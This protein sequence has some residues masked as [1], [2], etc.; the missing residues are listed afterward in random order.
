MKLRTLNAREQRV[1]TAI[2]LVSGTALYI[3]FALIV[4]PLWTKAM[5]LGRRVRAS[6]EELRALQAATANEAVIRDQYQSLQSSVGS[7][8][9][10]LPPEKDLPAVIEALSNIAR[11]TNVKIQTIFPQRNAADAQFAPAGTQNKAAAIPEPV[12]YRQIPIQVDAQSGY[13]QL[14][15]FLSLVEAE[16]S[17]MELRSLRVAADPREP[18]R[19]T[20]RMIIEAYFEAEGAA[21]HP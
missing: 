10:F 2:L 20:I 13:H 8:R 4:R 15:V 12:V 7:I 17:P 9:S 6:R 11:Q 3:Y 21:P 5:D 18:K 14:G 16:H 19:H 1:L